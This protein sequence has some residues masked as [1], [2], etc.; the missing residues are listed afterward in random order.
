MKLEGIGKAVVAALVTAAFLVPVCGCGQEGTGRTEYIVREQGVKFGTQV[1]TQ[2][3]EDRKKIYSST[4][5]FPCHFQDT[6]IYRNLTVSGDVKE[7]L[8]YYANRKVPGASYRT[9][10]TRGNSAYTYLSDELQT[11]EFLPEIFS[12]GNLIPLET[13]SVCLLQ[14]LLDRFLNLEVDRAV[15]YVIVPSASPLVQ[16]IAVALTGKKEALLSGEG[17]GEVTIAFDE[18]G[19]ITRVNDQG[20]GV[21]IVRNRAGRIDSKSYEPSSKGINIKE[22]RVET[23]DNLKLA[24]S[25]YLPRGEKPCPAVVLAPDFGPQNRTGN[26]LLSQIAVRLAEDGIAALCCDK[27]GVPESH[28]EYATYTF[29]SAKEDLNAQV[30]YLVLH[31]DIDIERVGI[32]GYGEGGALAAS[33]AVSNPY[34][35]ACVFMATPSVRLF[36][37]LELLDIGGTD[38]GGA[39]EQEKTGIRKA[40][41]DNLVR[42]VGL[43]EGDFIEIGEHKLF[44]GW[45]RSQMAR[46]PSADFSSINV[47]V[48]VMQGE[49]DEIIGMGQ[50]RQIVEYLEEGG[51]SD[52]ELM[53]Y[54]KLGHQFGPLVMSPPYQLHPQLSDNLLD[55]ISAWLGKRLV[56][57]R[58]E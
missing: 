2:E 14:G 36:P 3:I 57:N 7:T 30:D 6:T 56:E 34:I 53:S 37:D 22:I 15:A 42:L 12:P 52:V 48:L 21:E 43:T 29:D 18:D 51:N 16:E 50:A 55:D 35:S 49:Q 44:L 20:G 25:L 45:M 24:G 38:G 54:E 4:E 40:R 1:V 23:A 31:G 11:F 28:G 5:R 27:R 41:I 19:E 13:D 33:V 32:L 17:L 39:F 9:Y 47:P 58:A 8:G 46:D 10:L 26:G